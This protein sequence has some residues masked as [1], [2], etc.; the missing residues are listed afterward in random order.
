MGVGKT[1]YRSFQLHVLYQE[2]LIDDKVYVAARKQVFSIKQQ[3]LHLI[4]SVQYLKK[5][6]IGGKKPYVKKFYLRKV[7]YMTNNY[8]LY[9]RHSIFLGP[10]EFYVLV[11]AQ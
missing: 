7:V 1:R 8:F 2:V 9:K 11:T 5:S 3:V 4:A 10:F 6:F